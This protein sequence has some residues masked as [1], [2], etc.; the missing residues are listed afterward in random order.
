MS[1]TRSGISSFFDICG[2]SSF[3]SVLIVGAVGLNNFPSGP[4]SL[5]THY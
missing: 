5:K 4:G 2:M 1:L 3:G